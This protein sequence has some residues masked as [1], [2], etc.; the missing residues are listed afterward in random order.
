M[1]LRELLELLE[2]DEPREFEYFENMADLMESEES[3]PVETLYQLFSE[4]DPAIIGELVASY[5]DDLLEAVPDEA[6]ET[7][8]L[9]DSIKRALAGLARNLDD[10]GNLLRF[11]EELQRFRAFF[12]TESE[13]ICK[14]QADGEEKTLPLRDALTLARLQKLE[15]EE[16]QY[17]FA[18]CLRYELDEYV[19]GF[20]DLAEAEEEPDEEGDLL[21]RG[22][23]Y[24]DEMRD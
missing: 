22:Y 23:V 21:D 11:A 13:V 10:E 1:D 14:S 19:M 5:F 7:Y 2:I 6:T 12:T 24:D 16:Y 9:L 15:E 4:T 3:V 18:D 17:D 20:A 8:I